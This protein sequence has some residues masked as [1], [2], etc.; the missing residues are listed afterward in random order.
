MVSGNAMKPKEFVGD[1]HDIAH[2]E[3]GTIGET[4]SVKIKDACGAETFQNLTIANLAN[5]RFV[6]APVKTVCAGDVIYITTN[7][8]LNSYRWYPPGKDA[9]TNPNDYISIKRDLIIYNARVEDSGRYECQV[10]PIG[11]GTG[12][13]DF[14]EIVVL[15]C[16]APVNPHLMQ[17]V[18]YPI[19]P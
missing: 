10:I 9:I 16:T 6:T 1:N 11:C 19:A 14:V 17:R 18:Q 2:F 4:Y 5:F 15:P 13:R 7:I 8:P 3:H 12:L